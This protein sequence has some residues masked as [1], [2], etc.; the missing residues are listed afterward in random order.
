MRGFNRGLVC[1]FIQ[2]ACRQP[3]LDEKI[4][5]GE[6]LV[7]YLRGA[8]DAAARRFGLGINAG[9]PRDEPSPKQRQTR[10]VIR[11]NAPIAIGGFQRPLHRRPTLCRQAGLASAPDR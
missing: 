11:G 2:S 4:N 6:G 1:L 10:R 5:E 8:S 9:K 3:L 7:R